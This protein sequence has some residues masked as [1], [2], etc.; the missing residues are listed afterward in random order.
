MGV[1]EQRLWADYD[2]L[3]R[4]RSRVMHFTILSVTE[5]PEA[6]RIH[7]D[8]KSLTTLNNGRPQFK[9]GH[10]IEIRYTPE[11]PKQKPIVR[12]VSSPPPLH[13][14]IWRDRRVCIEDRWIPGI[15]IPLDNICELVGKLIAYQE[16]NLASPANNDPAL[17]AWVRARERDLPLDRSQIRLADSG[18]AI[19]WGDADDLP[20][21]PLRITF[22]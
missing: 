13:P 18:D 20:A 2:A 5:P 4:F 14:N 16:Y 1:R 7:Y 8:L 12:V 3:K 6:Y 19:Q 11:Y 21:P 22:G 17:L 15:G 10:D 9:A